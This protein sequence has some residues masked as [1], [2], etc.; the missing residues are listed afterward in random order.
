MLSHR[1][2]G[3]VD[4]YLLGLATSGELAELEVLVQTRSDV[5]DALVDASR[6]EGAL[7]ALLR[8]ERSQQQERAGVQ[9]LLAGAALEHDAP[10]PRAGLAIVMTRLTGWLSTPVRFGVFLA[11]LSC[12][13]L[14]LTTAQIRLDEPSDAT[15]SANSTQS[16]VGVISS[17]RETQWAGDRSP[18]RQLAAGAPLELVAGQAEVRLRQGV[19]LALSAPVSVQIKEG[20]ITLYGGEVRLRVP[21]RAQGFFVQTPSARV[22]DLGT[23]FSVRADQQGSTDVRVH[24]GTVLVHALNADGKLLPPQRLDAQQTA[25]VERHSPMVVVRKPRAPE[26]G[27]LRAHY[28]LDESPASPPRVHDTVAG[29]DG[30]WINSPQRGIAGVHG[31]A[32]A[33]HQSGVKLPPPSLQRGDRFT[34]SLWVRFAKLT[35]F[36]RLVDCTETPATFLRGYRVLG[37]GRRISFRVRSGLNDW[38]NLQHGSLAAGEWTFVAAR[39]DQDGLMQL[40][41]LPQQ[42]APVQAE[43]IAAATLR[44][45]CKQGSL[46]FTGCV[47]HLGHSRQ[48]PAPMHCYHGAMDDVAC[49]NAVL[50][51]AQLA[52]IYNEGAAALRDE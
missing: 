21:R 25:R 26:E 34:V 4:R 36:S 35:R 32:Y 17:T 10:A 14:L 44:E 6:L 20:G 22:V 33:F 31:S 2:A 28:P 18:Q 39:Y 40:T 1:A 43:T 50:T 15:A 48:N 45:P 16:P 30:I 19:T 38:Q 9:S 12:L 27:L 13:S 51:D 37:I 47:S 11:A 23:E 24:E 41:T 46:D 49:F 3:L 29:Q 52:R 8:Q 7:A 5:A 42:R